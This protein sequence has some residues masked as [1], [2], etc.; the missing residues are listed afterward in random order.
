[1]LVERFKAVG[2]R[3]NFVDAMMGNTLSD[4]QKRPFLES[5][6][7]FHCLLPFR[8]NEIGCA[9]SHYK[10]W[11]MIA[12]GDADAGFV[13]EDDAIALSQ[14][15]DYVQS[16]MGALVDLTPRLDLVMLH[17]SRPHRKKMQIYELAEGVDLSVVRFQEA[18]A[19]SYMMSK[20]TAKAML[21]H[22]LRHC[23]NVDTLLHRWWLHD[24]DVLCLNPPLFWIDNRDSSVGY[25]HLKQW[26][27][28][29]LHHKCAR[30][31]WRVRDSF[32]KRVRFRAY[33]RRARRRFL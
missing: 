27:S 11:Q 28:D 6:R 10:V 33:V 26:E 19:V 9:M 2:C 15:V 7:Q 1:M 29:G 8:D 13:F 25:S 14:D 24:Y 18:G 30:W 4:A 20:S 12:N 32:I 17:Q 16:I 31:W 5:N 21:N 22:R 23:L 3:V